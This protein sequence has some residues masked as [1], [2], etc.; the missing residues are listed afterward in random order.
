M[1]PVIDT[2]KRIVE[3]QGRTQTWVAN[4]MNEINPELCMDSVKFSSMTTGRRKM[5]ETN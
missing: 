4:K 3:E 2:V 1:I 5:S